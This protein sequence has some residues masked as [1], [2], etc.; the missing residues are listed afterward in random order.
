MA[1][2]TVSDVVGYACD[3]ALGYRTV[4]VA[5]SNLAAAG[6]RHVPREVTAGG[7]RN[8]TSPAPEHPVPTR[9]SPLPGL[10]ERRAWQGQIPDVAEK[11]AGAEAGSMGGGGRAG[12]GG[13]V[14]AATGAAGVQQGLVA[15]G[16]GMVGGQAGGEQVTAEDGTLGEGMGMSSRI[17][18]PMETGGHGEP[19]RARGTLASAGAASSAWMFAISPPLTPPLA[20]K[21]L[22]IRPRSSE[23]PLSA[24]AES[25]AIPSSHKRMACASFSPRLL[26]QLETEGDQLGGE[27]LEEPLSPPD[28]EMPASSSAEVE[29]IEEATEEGQEEGVS[30]VGD[31]EGEG[32]VLEPQVLR[33]RRKPAASTQSTSTGSSMG[34]DNASS[35]VT[36]PPSTAEVAGGKGGA[37]GALHRVPQQS[38]APDVAVKG[39]AG[40][41][42]VRRFLHAVGLTVVFTALV[43]VGIPGLICA[44]GPDPRLRPDPT[45]TDESIHRT[46]CFIVGKWELWA[47]WLAKVTGV[48]VAAR[49][50]QLVE[51]VGPVLDTWFNNWLVPYWNWLSSD[52]VQPYWKWALNDWL[53]PLWGW[54][55]NDVVLPFWNWLSSNWL[56]PYWDWLSIE[57]LLP[58]WNRLSREWLL[59]VWTRLSD[60]WLLP[61]WNYGKEWLS[62][63]DNQ[64]L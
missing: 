27:Q 51:W 48:A 28:R 64:V 40:M 22:H 63:G 15:A 50:T 62:S 38:H 56:L 1:P 30:E 37:L 12:A 6:N 47:R 33:Q 23:G 19:S 58:Y 5:E 16:D 20:S 44:L 60:D 43:L 2:R 25:P 36:E 55:S 8:G 4:Q 42:A 31:V 10:A 17:P 26:A 7:A 11:Q 14:D 3:A 57:W 24:M 39:T 9:A 46:C 52:V 29:E 61:L 41:G 18:A 53:L 35:L 21:A 49:A 54:L 59:P 13:G 34:W 32:G 45:P